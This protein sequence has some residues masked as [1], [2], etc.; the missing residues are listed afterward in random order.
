MEVS[1][2]EGIF[3][4]CDEDPARSEGLECLAVPLVT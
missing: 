4:S 2:V 3:M 1:K